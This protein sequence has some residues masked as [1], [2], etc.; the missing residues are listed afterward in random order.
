MFPRPQL[1]I[2]QQWFS[3]VLNRWQVIIWT[4]DG[5]VWWHIYASLGLKELITTYIFEVNS[6]NF[7]VHPHSLSQ[8]MSFQWFTA[9][10]FNSIAD[11]LESR[12]SCTNPS[13]WNLNHNNGCLLC[14]IKSK[15]HMLAA[16]AIETLLRNIIYTQ[17]SQTWFKSNERI[18]TIQPVVLYIGTY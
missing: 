6:L 10:K 18:C 12:L 11:A 16:V 4:S 2:S 14:E 9:R 15:L 1:T 13:I 8:S 3:L 7:H 5:L 17:C